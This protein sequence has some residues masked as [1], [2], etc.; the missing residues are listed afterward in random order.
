[1]VDAEIGIVT[2]VWTP[3]GRRRHITAWRASKRERDPLRRR[4]G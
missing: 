2:V 4:P 1:M 3:R